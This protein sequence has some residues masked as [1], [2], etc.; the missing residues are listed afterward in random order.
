MLQGVKGLAE[1][2]RANSSAMRACLT[3][4]E[5]DYVLAVDCGGDSLTGGLDFEASNGL[6]AVEMGRDRQVLTALHSSGVPFTHLVLGPGCDAESSVEAMVDAIDNL[7]SR[8]RLLGVMSL[9]NVLPVMRELSQT[10]APTRT[11]NLMYFALEHLKRYG[12]AAGAESFTIERWGRQA[13]IPYA[14]LT[15]AVAFAGGT[16]LPISYQAGDLCEA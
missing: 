10:L 14:W 13:T 15:V 1:V 7:Q 9:E 4:L 16:P 12:D 8:G 6:D 3:A 11:P 2:T 5:I